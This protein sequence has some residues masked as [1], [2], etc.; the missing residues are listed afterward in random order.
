MERIP[1]FYDHRMVVEIP[2]ES[3]SPRKP[4]EVVESWSVRY[5]IELR[6]FPPADVEDFC[7]AHVRDP[8]GGYLDGDDLRRRDRAVFESM[9]SRG[10]PVAWNLAGGY[11]ESTTDG[12]RSI[13]AVLDIHDATME[14]CLKVYAPHGLG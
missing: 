11:Q 14:E 13:R 7:L 6:D 9:R 12:V 1:V 5:P 4:R 3:P 10:I 2:L 8:L